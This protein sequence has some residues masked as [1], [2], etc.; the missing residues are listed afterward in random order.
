MYFD[1]DGSTHANVAGRK[2]GDTTTERAQA[3][4]TLLTGVAFFGR[5]QNS[6]AV[7]TVRLECVRLGCYDRKNFYRHM[8][9]VPG[10]VLSGS[11]SSRVLKAKPADIRDAMHKVVNLARGVK[12]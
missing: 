8:A 7:E 10:A 5:D 4:A 11:G 2:L 3:V 1:S 6:I 12:A 9:S